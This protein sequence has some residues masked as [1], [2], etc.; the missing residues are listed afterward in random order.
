MHS[1][2]PEAPANLT[3][4]SDPHRVRP[5]P[6]G[7]PGD[8]A[9]S[10]SVVS[11]ACIYR[12]H[13]SAVHA[14]ALR[15]CGPRLASD[16]TQEVFVR[17]WTH[18]EKF[19]PD[20]GSLRS[21]LLMMSR[22]KAVDAV[23][24][25]AVRHARELRTAGQSEPTTAG[26]DEDVLRRDI[27]TRVAV[28]LDQLHP[29]QKEAIVLAFYGGFSYRE[30][31]VIVGRAEGTIKGRIRAGLQKLQTTLADLVKPELAGRVA[32]IDVS[33]ADSP[34]AAAALTMA[35]SQVQSEAELLERELQAA[36][37]SRVAL[38]QAKGVINERDDVAIREAFSRLQAL[39][40]R[41]HASLIES[42]AG[43]VAADACAAPDDVTVDLT[44]SDAEGASQG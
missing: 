24:A 3:F 29:N 16:V 37:D 33:P 21:F 36:F 5:A 35:L 9:R 4:E 2:P 1:T 15:I 10:Q 13:R 11:F 8:A 18:P 42:A 14:L 30:V 39:A 20:R 38:E 41:D 43:V 31:A 7:S 32:S 17:L 23:R 26:A 6:D 19:D 12:E 25:E 40:R 22:H 44:N 27:A 28:G 34:L